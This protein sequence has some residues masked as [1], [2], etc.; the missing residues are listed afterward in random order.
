[1]IGI[2]RSTAS[3]SDIARA[4]VQPVPA[5]SLPYK[6]LFWLLF[7]I[8]VLQLSAT[9]SVA[10]DPASDFAP[11][12]L[13]I[14]SKNERSQMDSQTDA[15]SRTKIS[16]EFMSDRLS[17]AERNVENKDFDGLFRDLGDFNAVMDDC[18]NFLARRDTGSGKVLDNFKRLEI[19][20]REFIPRLESIRRDLPLRYEDYVRKLIKT[21]REARTKASDPLFADTVVPRAKLGQ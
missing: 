13:K 10:Q 9:V 12:P 17:D 5:A 11:P 20:L 16:L 7:A 4:T 2:I 14:L 15:K 18:L 6:G 3:C 19:G 8:F 21:V 1:M